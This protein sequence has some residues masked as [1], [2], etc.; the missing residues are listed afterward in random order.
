MLTH[1]YKHIAVAVVGAAALVTLQ[2]SPS[3]APQ[4][5]SPQDQTAARCAQ[6]TTMLTGRG[7]NAE[8]L[9][10]IVRNGNSWSYEDGEI[11]DV[12]RK[13]RAK[14]AALRARPADA[15]LAKEV[16]D[17]KAEQNR[18]AGLINR[19]NDQLSELRC[20]DAPPPVKDLPSRTTSGATGATGPRS[21]EALIAV[22]PTDPAVMKAWNERLDKA[23]PAYWPGAELRAK[24]F[25]LTLRPNLD[26]AGT[27]TLIEQVNAWGQRFNC[28]A[29][30]A[31]YGGEI[32][33][34]PNTTW[35]KDGFEAPVV[36][37]GAGKSIKGKFNNPSVTAGTFTFSLQE[38]AKGYVFF[39][40][41]VRRWN[42]AKQ[43]YVEEVSQSVCGDK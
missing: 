24:A 14:E 6:I 7:G 3:A 25:T 4:N 10:R 13:L 11:G 34:H 21:P 28:S 2:S 31:M 36:A 37:C 19:L 20:P 38:N 15:L 26:P 43:A 33:W 16:D 1:V 9:G 39:C 32:S 5:T 12:Q 35:G 22:V 29:D 18:L 30:S 23:G 27:R 41:T 17:L 40:G 42:S 8:G